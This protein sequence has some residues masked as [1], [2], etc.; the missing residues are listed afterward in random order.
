MIHGINLDAQDGE[1]V[2]TSTVQTTVSNDNQP[3]LLFGDP[4]AYSKMSPEKRDELTQKMMSKWSKWAGKDKNPLSVR[5]KK[6]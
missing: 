5:K 2:T 3:A 6:K 1:Q 4:A